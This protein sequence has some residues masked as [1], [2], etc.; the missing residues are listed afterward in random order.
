MAINPFSNLFGASAFDEASPQ[1]YSMLGTDEPSLSQMA[2]TSAPM[3]TGFQP[4]VPALIGAGLVPFTQL[5]PSGGAIPA[6]GLMSRFAPTAAALLAAEEAPKAFG[7]EKST[8]EILTELAATTPEE[9][10]G[11]A[12]YAA[13]GA[14]LPGL[15]GEPVIDAGVVS[16]P[17]KDSMIGTVLKEP[18]NRETINQVMSQANVPQL[19]QQVLGALQGSQNQQQFM[20]GGVQMP[21][22]SGTVLKSPS[23]VMIGAGVPTMEENVAG[24]MS[25]TP[26]TAPVLPEGVQPGSPQANFLSRQ[27][28]G[29]Q[30]TPEQVTQ[31]QEFAGSI[32]TTFDPQTGYSRDPF[33]Q[34]QEQQAQEEAQRQTSLT[35]PLPGQSLSQF[36]RYED[37]PIQRTEQFVEPGTGRLRRRST[38]AA[39]DLMR[40][41]GFDIPQG[42]RPLAPELAGFEQDAGIREQRLRDQAALRERFP[43]GVPVSS[44]LAAMQTG[45]MTD[46]ERRRFAKG[47]MRGASEGDIADSLEI[48]NRY[49]L[50]PRTGEP[51]QTTPSSPSSFQEKVSALI[52]TGASPED[53]VS[54]ALGERDTAVRPSA[55]QEKLDALIATGVSPEEATRRALGEKSI[56]Q[57]GPE[58]PRTFPQ[59][60]GRLV[61]V[62]PNEFFFVE[63]PVVEKPELSVVQ[64]E[65]EKGVG[66]D[67]AEFNKNKASARSNI[68][69][70]DGLIA[71]LNSK[72][73][74][75]G[76][77]REQFTPA[78]LGIDDATRAFFNP[79]GQDAVDR[80]RLVVF[81]SLR[82]TL[83]AAFTEAEGQRLTKA[84]YNSNLSPEL[85]IKR[86]EDVK[87][88][89]DNTLAAREA[90]LDFFTQ[91]PGS[92]M[93]DFARQGGLDAMDVFESELRTLEAQSGVTDPVGGRRATTGRRTSGSRYRSKSLN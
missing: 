51:I 67:L 56:A 24:M 58:G 62:K 7:S 74:S 39:V 3:D 75:V 55:F 31:A 20:N 25:S 34:S 47:L 87:S 21:T 12:E 57:F 78:F 72:E 80:V 26:G 14:N 33:L 93:I 44:R 83:G 70:Y 69:I 84:T 79:V 59:D 52:A 37:Q 11:A 8:S 63:D 19:D 86:L 68:K 45:T 2:A 13:L 27:A 48:A 36:M 42:V 46:A 53:A 10:A 82:D 16:K 43:G 92:T 15:G 65:L 61:E 4:M 85:N 28:S 22:G 5:V 40:Q 17:T 50:D 66:K 6:R 88:V 89:L 9:R 54:R 71:G 32:G 90:E 23:Q 76:T 49:N 91:N 30:M 64:E 77:I 60:G 38:G 81:Q 29:Q 35:G 1:Q 41:D 18:D 73:I